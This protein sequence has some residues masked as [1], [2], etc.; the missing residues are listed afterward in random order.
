[1]HAAGIVADHATESAPGVSGWIGSEGEMEFFG[2]IPQIIAHDSGLNAG[3]SASRIDLDQVMHVLREIHQHG[4]VAT[5]P[6]ETGAAAARKDRRAE[7]SAERDRFLHILRIP[8]NDH[9]DGRLAVVRAVGS[10]ERAAASVEAD[11]A[12]DPAAQFGSERFGVDVDFS[13]TS[14]VG[15]LKG[16]GHQGNLRL[17]IRRFVADRSRFRP[18]APAGIKSASLSDA[19]SKDRCGLHARH[20]R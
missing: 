5:L 15:W 19:M 6:R 16:G 20:R 3:G 14:W 9:A 2:R 18:S 13:R 11:F 7:L 17:A 12:F 10:V 4:D 1:M 8:R